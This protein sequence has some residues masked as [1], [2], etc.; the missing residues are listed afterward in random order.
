MGRRQPNH[1]S[2]CEQTHDSAGAAMA[3]RRGFLDRRALRLAL[4]VMVL[5][6]GLAGALLV[7]VQV[8][9]LR[10]R[11]AELEDTRECLRA[12]SASLEAT[13]TAATDR[14]VV[15]DRAC[16]ELGLESPRDPD[17]VLVMPAPDRE[18]GP[19]QRL[20]AGLTAGD[21]GANSVT[22]A[23]LLAGAMVSLQPRA[24]HAAPAPGTLP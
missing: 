12:Q 7:S 14:R 4:L 5:A 3:H 8:T 20:L 18:V 15:R 10:T 11:V 17:F 16:R 24:A 21:D 23:R 9:R 22:P 19:W 6:S 2:P 1:W 13:W